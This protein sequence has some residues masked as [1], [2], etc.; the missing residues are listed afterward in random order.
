MKK[1]LIKRMFAVVLAGTLA[2]GLLAG[3]GS[4]KKDSAGTTDTK[5]ETK[6]ETGSTD[7]AAT[8][9][10]KPDTWIADR[11]IT[12]QA[13]V[14]DIGYSLP[15]D[16]NNTPV[17]QEITKRT[18]I[19]LNIQYT[20]GDSDSKVMASQLAAGT[21]PDVII[22]Y[23]DN[24]T[25]K[26]FPMLLKA[27]K[28]GMFADLSSYLP[29]TQVFSKYAEDG[30]LPNDAYKNVTFRED[31]DGAVYLL[32]MA[33]DEVDRSM[34]YNPEDAY[35]GGPY[36]QKSIADEL[37]ID[38]TQVKTSED[39][40][41][42]LVKIKEGNFKDDNGNPVWPLG[43]K[44]WGGSVDSLK[45]NI[46]ELEWGVSDGYN[47][48][49][50][51]NIYHE[52][53]TDYVYDK[54]N[55]V[56]KLLNEGL[57]NP[58][59]F[60]MDSTRAEEVSKTKNSAIIGDIHN[61]Q[62]IIYASEDWIPVG[63]LNDVEGDN[64]KLTSGKTARGCMAISAEAEN[65]E[66]ILKFFDFLS[67]KEGQLL[68]EYGVEGV[69]Y[70]MVDGFPVL[71]DETLEKLNA[72]DT[73]WLINN[74]G[75]SFGGA[76]NYFFEF[77]LTNM[78][79]IDNFGESR[80]GAKSSTTFERSVEIAETYPREYKMVKGLKATAYLTSPGLE[81]VKTQMDLLNYNEV[82]T[83][84]FFAKSDAEVKTIIESFRAQLKAAGID[85]FKAKLKEIYDADK[86]AIN[87]YN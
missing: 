35:L 18:G 46:G 49:K 25:R 39:F 59:Y 82:L 50:D 60:T 56:R 14:D 73:D 44:F 9:S 51:G 71:T 86:D 48:D 54:I 28:E 27:A 55:Y 61:Y 74:V 72:G 5:T 42:L 80:P 15:K 23:L 81:A 41:N 70:N 87:F 11:T 65:P 40:Y 22:S 78:N 16:L 24:S 6:T 12:V 34:E 2:T 29:N 31:L 4:D 67:T 58:E 43:P 3:C 19:K 32:Q 26:E 76:A 69:S 83:Q 20:P 66:E 68:C 13:Y 57:M 47:I 53:E 8:D 64:K 62:E 45:F 37:G 7:S 1:N 52:V 21:I 10:G 77:V 85:D 63:P 38:V 84:A 33:I 17:M 36:I 75:A 30:F 79:N